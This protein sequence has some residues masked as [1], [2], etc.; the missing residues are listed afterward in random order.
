[1]RCLSALARSTPGVPLQRAFVQK[2]QWGPVFSVP[3]ASIS[4]IHHIH[5]DV[6]VQYITLVGTR[7]CVFVCEGPPHW[8]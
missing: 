7:V 6:C 8:R 4:C 1:M 3:P 5:G 2:L